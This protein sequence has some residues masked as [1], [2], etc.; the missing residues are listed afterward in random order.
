VAAAAGVI[1]QRELLSRCRAGE[2]GAWEELVARFSRYVY[3]IAV[4]GFRLEREDAEDAFQEVFLRVFEHLDMLRDE[5]AL[6][7]WIGQ[8]A[9]RVCLDRVRARVPSPAGGL[10]VEGA[11]LDERLARL[12][13]ALSVWEAFA[14]LSEPCRDVLDRLFWRDESY[15]VIG[16]A[17]RVPAGTVASRVSRCLERLRGM[18]VSG[19]TGGVVG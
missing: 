5:R 10:E 4:R 9:R 18:L 3:G 17:L 2:E 11:A 8:V 1:E 12:D 19:P 14:R 7:S 15:R 16:E 6:R 13:E